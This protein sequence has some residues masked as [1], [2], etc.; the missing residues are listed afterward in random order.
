MTWV[1]LM[2]KKR[3]DLGRVKMQFGTISG[4]SGFDF[5]PTRW[6]TSYVGD[7]VDSTSVSSAL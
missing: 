6:A 5:F 2:T 7:S 1:D 4:F 3:H